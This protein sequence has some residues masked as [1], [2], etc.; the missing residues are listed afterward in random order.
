MAQK[1]KSAGYA[2][3]MSGKWHLGFYKSV[4]ACL[5]RLA[6]I[7]GALGGSLRFAESALPAS[8]SQFT[9]L[10]TLACGRCAL[11][12]APKRRFRS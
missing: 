10:A 11:L 12:P 9:W 2:T 6:L 4:R 7:R 3:A 1:F 8:P 5:E